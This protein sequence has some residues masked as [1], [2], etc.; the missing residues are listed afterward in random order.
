[1][2]IVFVTTSFRPYEWRSGISNVV[3][4]L[5]KELLKYDSDVT[6]FSPHYKGL[7]KTETK[8]GIRVERF[9]YS[10]N[11]FA[12]SSE[13]S[14]MIVNSKPDLVHSFHYGFYPAIAGL[15]AAKTVSS[16]HVLTPAYHPPIYSIIK[17]SLFYFYDMTYGKKLIS[18]SD[19]LMV[20]NKNEKVQ[21]Q[22]Y[23]PR[24]VE[25]IPPPVNNDIFYPERHQRPKITIAYVGSFLPW[26]GAGVAFD[27]F[28]Q[29]EKEYNNL[30]FFF[31]GGGTMYKELKSKSG[32]NFK[33]FVEQS[34][35]TLA[36]LYNMADIVV[37]PTYYES[38]GCVLAEA[39][40]CGTPVVSTK[41]GAV[42]ETVGKG[43]ILVDYGDWSAM[44]TSI[45]RL[46]E[47]TNL[48]RKMSKKAI[49]Q[50]T[51][52]KKEK[53]AIRVYKSYKYLDKVGL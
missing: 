2:K 22:K 5:G 38:F 37:S 12:Y 28:K 24:K 47:D 50:S 9:N 39:A 16:P 46:I 42:P 8:N 27:I 1:M 21:M 44:K 49:R 17:K 11:H 19:K 35:T 33:F 45:I 6:V 26:K 34:S 20:F 3:Y 18:N 14:N 36:K 15:N 4:L 52:Y 51:N 29:L 53:V 7:Q 31:I 41:V 10:N 23:K 43:G 48:R 40:M 32:K 13:A 25:V 30:E